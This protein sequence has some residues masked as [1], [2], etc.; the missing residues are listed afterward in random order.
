[1]CNSLLVEWFCVENVLGLN[2]LLKLWIILLGVVVGECFKGVEGWLWGW[3]ECLEV[4]MLV[5]VVKDR[6]EFCLLYD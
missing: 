2:I 3:L 6:W 1:M 5:W 4:R